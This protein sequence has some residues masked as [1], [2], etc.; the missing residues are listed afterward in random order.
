M[1]AVKIKLFAL[2]EGG[3]TKVE[4]VRGLSTKFL[5]NGLALRSSEKYFVTV[6]G[7]YAMRS[8]LLAVNI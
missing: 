2:I 3:N 7:I 1:G 6:I 4:T 8:L 5:I